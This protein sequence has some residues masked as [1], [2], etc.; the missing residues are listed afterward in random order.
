MWKAMNSLIQRRVNGRIPEEYACQHTANLIRG[1]DVQE[2][3]ICCMIAV[4]QYLH[5]AISLKTQRL[6]TGHKPENNSRRVSSELYTPTA[7]P[8]VP[9][10]TS[11]R[12]LQ[13]GTHFAPLVSLPYELFNPFQADAARTVGLEQRQAMISTLPSQT[14]LETGQWKS[15][16]QPQ[17]CM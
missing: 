9:Y 8:R 15:S 14:V 2:Q 12:P 7:E 6:R 3:E 1:A 4:R 11:S 5:A 16:R 10:V 13:S 17:P